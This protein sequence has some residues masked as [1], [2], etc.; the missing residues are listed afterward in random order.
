MSPLSDNTSAREFIAL[1]VQAASSATDP[2][3]ADYFSA[4]ID[5]LLFQ[6]EYL[7]TCYSLPSYTK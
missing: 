6:I 3:E 7:E 5:Q 1:M 4:H 2:K